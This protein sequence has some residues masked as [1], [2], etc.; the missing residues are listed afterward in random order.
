MAQGQN[1]KSENKASSKKA[2]GINGKG[3]PYVNEMHE[4]SSDT[5]R[6]EFYKAVEKEYERSNRLSIKQQIQELIAVYC[7]EDSE[8]E[9]L[10]CIDALTI[11]RDSIILFVEKNIVEDEL[12]LKARVD[13]INSKK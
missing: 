3:A 12:K 2:T 6:R 5:A 7:T 13:L 9:Y 1:K 8:K 4:S 11:V 10:E